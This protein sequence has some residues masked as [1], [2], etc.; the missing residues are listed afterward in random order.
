MEFTTSRSSAETT[1][2]VEVNPPAKFQASDIESMSSSLAEA[3]NSQDISTA[4]SDIA[5]TI[6]VFSGENDSK[7]SVYLL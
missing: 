2:D 7:K 1:L 4:L 6:E 5:S 3:L